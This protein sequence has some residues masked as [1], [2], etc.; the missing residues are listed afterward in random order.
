MIDMMGLCYLPSMWMD[1][2]LFI[3]EDVARF[4]RLVTGGEE[5]VEELMTVG[6]R[7]QASETVFN[8]LHA[9]F[10]RRESL[11]PA[12][13]TDQ[14]VSRGPFK[15]QKIDLAT[16]SQ[17]LDEYYSLR[18]W[19]PVTGWPTKHVLMELGMAGYVAAVEEQGLR[20]PD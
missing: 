19:D 17:M 10:G 1:T 15:G 5:G 14:A 12:K 7:I 6:E 16:Y 4:Y 8:M 18:G 20:L 11:P 13:L 3:P 2:T 9:G